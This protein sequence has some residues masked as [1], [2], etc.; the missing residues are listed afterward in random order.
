MNWAAH[1]NELASNLPILSR[2]D[3]ERMLAEVATEEV[4]ILRG[5]KAEVRS[6]VFPMMQA[7]ESCPS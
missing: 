4:Y 1:Q 7:I 6:P 3:V 2:M 5:K